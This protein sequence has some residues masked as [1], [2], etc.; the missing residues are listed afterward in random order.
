MDK[1]VTDKPF[2]KEI[3]KTAC[4]L[5]RD[6]HFKLEENDNLGYIA[7]GEE[8]PMVFADGKTRASAEMSWRQALKIT[9]ATMLEVGSKLPEPLPSSHRHRQ[10]SKSADKF[11]VFRKV[12]GIEFFT[13]DKQNFYLHNASGSGN[14]WHTESVG[15]LKVLH[16]KLG[17]FIEEVEK[18]EC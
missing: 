17:E 5:S 18:K 16:K 13:T 6:Y 8:F 15:T 4:D 2:A 1:D 14:I 3:W 9:I 10:E 7:S 12:A 11:E